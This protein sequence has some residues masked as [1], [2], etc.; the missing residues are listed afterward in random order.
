M[1]TS[2]E[3]DIASNRRIYIGLSAGLL[4]ALALNVAFYF[5][6]ATPSEVAA[7]FRIPQSHQMGFPKVFWVEN[8]RGT[9][10]PRNPTTHQVLPFQ[11]AFYWGAFLLDVVFALGIAIGCAQWYERHGAPAATPPEESPSTPTPK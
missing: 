10:A 7:K 6:S 3:L 9:A 8:P 4:L 1:T 5:S 2:D 11:P